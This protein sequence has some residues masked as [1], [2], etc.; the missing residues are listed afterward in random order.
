M[1]QQ[2]GEEEEEEAAGREQRHNTL[3][4]SP[5]GRSRAVFS[6]GTVREVQFVGV[7]CK[8][9]QRTFSIVQMEICQIMPK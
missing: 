2:A 7:C 9:S 6:S 5:L 1:R 3:I 4:Q 8:H